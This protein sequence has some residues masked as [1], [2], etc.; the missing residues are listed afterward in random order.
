MRSDAPKSA[1]STVKS[2]RL[3]VPTS[4]DTPASAALDGVT[5]SAP[6]CFL[7]GRP[8]LGLPGLASSSCDVGWYP[9]KLTPTATSR[10]SAL[11]PSFPTA[12]FSFCRLSQSPNPAS[13][14]SVGM[15]TVPCLHWYST[16]SSNH[17]SH[18][19]RDSPIRFVSLTLASKP[20]TSS[21]YI[22]SC[23]SRPK[24]RS[25][26]TSLTHGFISSF[27]LFSLGRRPRL[28]SL[29]GPRRPPPDT[30]VRT[31]YSSSRRFH[32]LFGT[33]AR[34]CGTSRMSLGMSPSLAPTCRRHSTAFRVLLCT[35]RIIFLSTR[36][37]PR[38][39]TLHAAAALM[40]ATASSFSNP[41]SS[42]K[43]AASSALTLRVAVC[44]RCGTGLR[45]MTTWGKTSSFHPS[46]RRS[47]TMTSSVSSFVPFLP[48]G[49]ARARVVV[50]ARSALG[51][52]A[53]SAPSDGRSSSESHSPEP[54]AMALRGLDAAARFLRPRD[55]RDGIVGPDE[56]DA[57]DPSF[58][59][60]PAGS[61]PAALATTTHRRDLTAD[62]PRP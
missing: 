23:D 26:R 18:V 2:T 3:S 45:F 60:R 33:T 11:A 40:V 1:P 49:L 12:C 15:F 9:S 13:A 4:K 21:M 22:C 32:S 57:S 20:A 30:L 47:R 10:L 61:P 54:V 29:S 39:V 41:S 51:G 5:V 17:I 8:R 14:R 25:S 62:T 28:E 55:G 36:A 7:R 46:P 31:T 44:V 53:L 56:V 38:G 58:P 50:S 52:A 42:R 19:R 48:R 43:S 35:A 24:R 6:F 37:R 34:I 59:R 27:F 16:S